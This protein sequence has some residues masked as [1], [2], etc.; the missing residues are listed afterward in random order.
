MAYTGLN[1]TIVLRHIRR[2]LG[3]IAYD[4]ELSDEEIMQV[5]F[6]HTLPT[7]SVYFPYRYRVLV[8]PQDEIVAG[9][10]CY[11]L[12]NE[13]NMEI[14]G[15]SKVS[16]GDYY[17]YN[18]NSSMNAGMSN[19]MDNQVFNDFLS[20]TMTKTTWHYLAPNHI[21][22]YPRIM[23]QSRALITVKAIHPKHLRSIK[24]SLREQFLK[25]AYLDV[26]ESLYPI[27]KRFESLNSPY[28]NIQLFMDA[29]ERAHDEREEL[30][31]KFQD[32]VLLDSDSPRI[33]FG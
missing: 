24:Q 5:V 6:Q 29:V 26:L 18:Y 7:F 22:I 30:L 28:G 3:A 10:S 32:N 23:G 19:P 16:V 31:L 2:E 27:R 25:L 11:L 14:I 17:G 9:K 21:E 1:P 15:I 13:D 20:M 33:F 4:L 12:P 8:G